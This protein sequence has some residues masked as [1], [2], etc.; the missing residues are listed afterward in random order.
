LWRLAVWVLFAGLSFALWK[1]GL[2][3]LADTFTLLTLL[4]GRTVI[5]LLTGC[6]TVGWSACFVN[7]NTAVVSALLKRGAF[8][9]ARGV[10]AVGRGAFTVCADTFPVPQNFIC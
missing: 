1:S 3:I 8:I 4:L 6:I 9:T 2:W 5:W 7:A 10:W